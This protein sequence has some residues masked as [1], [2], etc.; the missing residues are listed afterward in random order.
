MGGPAGGWRASF[1]IGY[2]VLASAGSL[3][4][5]LG[6]GLSLVSPILSHKLMH[7]VV[8][9]LL[10]HVFIFIVSIVGYTQPFIHLAWS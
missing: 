4:A 8:W 10:S 3:L 6:I 9:L 7:F 1:G 5:L 2:F